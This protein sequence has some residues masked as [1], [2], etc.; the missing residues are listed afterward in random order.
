M[1][2]DKDASKSDER[3]VKDRR[4]TNLLTQKKTGGKHIMGNRGM[5]NWKLGAFFIMSLMLVA[6][7][8]SNTAMAAA[9]D[10]KGKVTVGWDASAP[11]DP[12]PGATI[13]S[14]TDDSAESPVVKIAAGSRYN[15]L[16]FTYTA[17]TGAADEEKA[18]NMAGGRVR[19]AFPWAVSNKFVTVVANTAADSPDTELGNSTGVIYQT[20]KDGKPVDPGSSPTTLIADLDADV[21][22]AIAASAVS[23]SG[24][25]ITIDL[26]S[27]W[28]RRTTNVMRSLVITFRDVTASKMAGSVTF[29][30]SSSARGGNLRL[31]ADAN[32]PS[33]MVGNIHGTNGPTTVDDKMA[34]PLSRNVEIT[35]VKVYPGEK[36]HRFTITFTAPGTMDDSTLEITIP[37]GLQPDGDPDT[38][39]I[40]FTEDLLRLGDLDISVLGRGGAKLFPDNPE[41][42]PPNAEDPRDDIRNPRISSTGAGDNE[43]GVLVID[44]EKI[45][46]G[47]RVVVTYVIDVPAG[48]AALANVEPDATSHFTATTQIGNNA[49]PVTSITG[50][51]IGKS[52]GS[53]RMQISPISLEAGSKGKNLHPDLYRVYRSCRQYSN[54]SE[55]VSF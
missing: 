26:G 29:T 16:Q 35:P 52:E 42:S 31:L 30:S 54:Y 50:G 24:S 15:A 21:K 5:T 43:A 22:A 9:N 6:A 28:G 32:Q 40:Q 33:V 7:V 2:Q 55:R 17:F 51:L 47:Q 4:N 34:D 36:K 46:E 3:H 8:F 13:T 45:S 14:F 48:A 37:P 41:D 38:L 19:I 44:I 20:D 49:L 18:I 53:G 23:L 12:E 10:G 39:G 25:N 11:I 27:E 1:I